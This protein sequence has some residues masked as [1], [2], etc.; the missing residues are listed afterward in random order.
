MIEEVLADDRPVPFTAGVHVGPGEG[1]LEVQYTAIRLRSPDRTQFKYWM[2]RFDKDWTDAGQR[3]VAYYTN[4]PA[5]SYR[6]HVVAF[7]RNDP[8]SA[9]EQILSIEWRPYFY[10]TSWFLALCAVVALFIAWLSYRVH[11]RNIRKRFAAVIEE[12]N[13]LAR[14]M[15]DT[16]IQGCVGVS[17]LLEAASGARDVSPQLSGELLERARSEVRA[18]VDEARLAV[19]NLRQNSEAGDDLVAAVSDLTRRVGL[20]TGIPVRCEHTGAPL[21]LG[22]DG[23]RSLLLLIREALHNAVRHGAP[24]H[25]TVILD[26]GEGTMDVRIE[27]DGC[28]FDASTIHP[29]NGHYGLIG[30]RERVEKL[31]GEFRLTSAPGAGTK[32]RLTIPAMK[33]APSEILN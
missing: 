26:F 23:Q 9:D 25:L 13:R 21:T 27:D 17:T 4:L 28:G 30:M 19:W 32:V 7:Q 12:R 11:V 5:G 8:R 3:H 15:H 2:E 6:F 24:K 18:T 14:E 10:R 16:L 22:T 33:T 31:G 29:M 20:E 1:K